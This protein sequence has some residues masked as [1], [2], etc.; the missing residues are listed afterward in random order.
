MVSVDA[1]HCEPEISQNDMHKSLEKR[2]HPF[3]QMFLISG[4][5]GCRADLQNKMA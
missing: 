2:N 4:P 3:H 1:T 5:L